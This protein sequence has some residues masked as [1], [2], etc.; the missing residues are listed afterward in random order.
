[1]Q[2]APEPVWFEGFLHSIWEGR[3]LCSAPLGSLVQRELAAV[4][5]TEGLTR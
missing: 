4:R 2:K 3:S 5:L 1:M